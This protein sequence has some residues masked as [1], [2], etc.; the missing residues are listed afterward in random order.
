MQKNGVGHMHG[1]VTVYTSDTMDEVAWVGQM[2]VYKDGLASG[3]MILLGV[4]DYKGM[5]LKLHVE[6]TCPSPAYFEL[7][8]RLLNAHGG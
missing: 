1:P 3:E 8:G 2:H 6:E 7:E 4:G 5:Q